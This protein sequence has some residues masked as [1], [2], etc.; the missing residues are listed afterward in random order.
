MTTPHK[1]DREAAERSWRRGRGGKN[2]FNP[3]WLL[4]H[5]RRSHAIT[6]E[7]TLIVKSR[8]QRSERRQGEPLLLIMY[9]C[10]MWV[11][12]ELRSFVGLRMF[13]G[14]GGCR[15]IARPGCR[16]KSSEVESQRWNQQKAVSLVGGPKNTTPA[17]NLLGDTELTLKIFVLRARTR[18]HVGRGRQGSLTGPVFWRLLQISW[19]GGD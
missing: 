18:H 1:A 5:P 15:G 6:K 14:M 10:G 16:C 3:G 8:A 9:L 4:H 2:P 13:V 7:K 19:G 12:P 11:L 17:I